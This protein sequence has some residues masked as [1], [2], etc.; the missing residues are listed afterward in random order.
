MD[1]AK[2]DFLKDKATILRKHVIE[3]VGRQGQG[4][5]QQGL[6]ASDIFS[7]LFFDILNL[8]FEDTEYLQAQVLPI[9]IPQIISSLIP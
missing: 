4:Y 7:V 1:N 6:G 3:M 8:D 5:V 9:Q 2:I